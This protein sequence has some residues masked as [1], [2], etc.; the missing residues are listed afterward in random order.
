MTSSIFFWVCGSPCKWH[1]T[2]SAT[3]TRE[4]EMEKELVT[5]SA[6]CRGGY[7]LF[8]FFLVDCFAFCSYQGLGS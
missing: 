8:T 3:G 7:P 1:R 2:T 5:L 4:D 6:W